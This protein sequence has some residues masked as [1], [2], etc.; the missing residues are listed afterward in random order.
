MDIVRPNQ[1]DERRIEVLVDGLPLFHGAQVAVDTTLVSALRRDGTP[2]PRC[3]DVDGAALEAARRRKELRYP[4]LSGRQERTR[5]VVLVAEVGG[6][7]SQE[8]AH[9]LLQTAKAGVR[10]EPKVIRV[11]AQC[12]WLRR[13]RC[14][15]AYSAARAFALSLLDCRAGLGSDGAT[16]N[17]I[18]CGW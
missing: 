11:S 4:E 7:W 5:L 16:P 15:L 2:R 17:H 9:F 8:T 10:H 12:A 1:L 6:R 3:V 13:W 14:L 18:R